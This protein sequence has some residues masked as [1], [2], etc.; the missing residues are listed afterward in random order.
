MPYIGSYIWK[1]RQKLGHELLILPSADTVAVRDDGAML[2]IFNK[3]AQKWFF[4]GGYA[5]ENQTSSECAARELL[6]ESGLKA[7]PNDLIPFAFVSGHT[8]VYADEDT[9]Q[10]FSQIFFTH[11]WEDLGANDLDSV[12]IEGRRW[13]TPDEIRATDCD[14]RIE[15][16][17]TAY[18]AYNETGKYQM[19]ELRENFVNP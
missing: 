3:D 15:K 19:I 9:N 17:L 8:V 12:E 7:D 11:K 6:E 16:I 10:P 18:E 2:M 5:E 13:M 4:P 1:I 14:V